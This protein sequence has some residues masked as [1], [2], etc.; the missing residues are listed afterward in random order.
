MWNRASALEEPRRCQLDHK[1]LARSPM[2]LMQARHRATRTTRAR[3]PPL[4]ANPRRRAS[5]SRGVFTEICSR[6]AAT[7]SSLFQLQVIGPRGPIG[8]H[9]FWMWTVFG[10]ISAMAPLGRFN[11]GS[12][13]ILYLH[14]HRHAPFGGLP[15]MWTRVLSATPFFC[16]LLALGHLGS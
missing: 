7:D 15:P 14:S 9:G 3:P 4:V 16:M 12:G 13:F 6:C 8:S 2:R 10:F 5:V 11:T 1:T